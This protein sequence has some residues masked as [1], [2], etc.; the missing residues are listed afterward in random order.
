[1]SEMSLEAEQEQ[2]DEEL[3]EAEGGEEDLLTEDDMWPEDNV[4]DLS[5]LSCKRHLCQRGMRV[6]LVSNAEISLFSTDFR[7][8]VREAPGEREHGMCHCRVRDALCSCG[9]TVGYHV[10][11]PGSG[12]VQQR[13][14]TTTTGSLTRETSQP[15]SAWRRASRWS[16]RICPSSN[17]RWRQLSRLKT[18]EMRS[19]VSF[20]TRKWWSP[21]R[22]PAATLLAA[23]AWFVPWTCGA[24]APTADKPPPVCSLQCRPAPALARPAMTQQA[25]PLK[26]RRLRKK[27]G[28]RE[29]GEFGNVADVLLMK[30]SLWPIREDQ[31]PQVVHTVD[32]FLEVVQMQTHLDRVVVLPRGIELLGQGAAAP[33]Q[34]RQ[35]ASGSKSVREVLA[36]L[37]EVSQCFRARLWHYG[38]RGREKEIK[39]PKK[40]TAGKDPDDKKCLAS[41]HRELGAQEKDGKVQSDM[42]LY[43]S[44]LRWQRKVRHPLDNERVKTATNCDIFD[45]APFAR[46]LPLW[47]RSE[48]GIFVGERGAGSG[49]HV[50]QCLWSNVG[51]NWCGFKLFAVWPWLERHSILDD[52]G[53]GTVFCPPLTQK[54]EEFLSR[55]KTVALVGP[56]D[57][58]VFS[59]GQPHTALCVGDGVNICAY[60]RAVMLCS[61][62]DISKIA[63]DVPVAVCGKLFHLN[64]LHSLGGLQGELQHSLGI[65]EQEFEV[66]D[67]TGRRICTDKQ[68]QDAVLSS[69]LPL[70][71]NLSDASVHLIENRRE[72]LAQMQWK[73]LRDKLRSS[74]TDMHMLRMQVSDLQQQLERKCKENDEKLEALRGDVGNQLLQDRTGTEAMLAQMSER[75]QSFTNLIHAEQNKREYGTKTQDN[76]M[77]DLRKAIDLERHERVKELDGHLHMLKEGKVALEVQRQALELLGASAEQHRVAESQSLRAEVTKDAREWANMTNQ[78]LDSLRSSLEGVS[79]RLQTQCDVNRQMTEKTEQAFQ[80][81]QKMHDI[82]VHSREVDVRLS[83]AST[84]FSERLQRISDRQEQLWESFDAVRVEKQNIDAKAN[85]SINQ[86]QDLKHALLKTEEDARKSLE[87]E[88][89]L[90][91][92]EISSLEQKLNA[93]G[94]KQI[95]DLESRCSERFERES[96]LRESHTKTTIFN[97]ISRVAHSPEK[98]EAKSEKVEE[99]MSPRQEPSATSSPQS[100]DLNAS[101]RICRTEG[102]GNSFVLP[103]AVDPRCGSMSVPQPTPSPK[104]WTS[105]G[106]LS[107]GM[108]GMASPVSTM[109]PRT[110]VYASP[111]SPMPA[112]SPVVTTPRMVEVRAPVFSV[113]ANS[114][115][116]LRRH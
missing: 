70:Q 41:L 50:D 48:G 105:F 110:G 79:Q 94:L 103:G 7:P 38:Q 98:G 15:R 4:L 22:R 6:H 115:E 60:D 67:S 53:K 39:V 34:L 44:E 83:Q 40:S 101:R 51:R 19:T 73:V 116:T 42:A 35:A 82:E 23:A 107:P 33:E 1:M 109:A 77:E 114:L 31:K 2:A 27:A 93:Q 69:Q 17:R 59:G 81:A 47:E 12:T 16:G 84:N 88:A 75:I 18:R 85:S 89:S 112:M 90:V 14:T 92:T 87:K 43:I 80:L 91:R 45:V 100:E 30:E 3:A 5:C 96:T 36:N 10:I 71:A 57:V 54:E 95:S 37:A 99:Q 28:R 68:L 63:A 58:W 25:R 97:E 102:G 74:E 111:R 61:P 11:L 56:G 24:N 52:A 20:A 8:H 66:S 55:A 32:E 64:N 72:E 9:C 106:R 29:V 62:T 113:R 108:P 46:H 13:V 26:Q 78:Q 65:Q 76:R 104:L 21:G 86:I 49:L